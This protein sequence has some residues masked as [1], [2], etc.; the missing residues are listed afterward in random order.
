MSLPGKRW[1]GSDAEVCVVGAADQD[2]ALRLQAALLREGVVCY[3]V[4]YIA[5]LC[6]VLY[7]VLSV[8]LC[9]VLRCVCCLVLCY[10]VCCVICRAA[11][12][13]FLA[14]RIVATGL[15]RLTSLAGFCR[16]ESVHPEDLQQPPK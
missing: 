3:A 8:V 15:A 2:A 5:V 13:C 6:V 12:F 4:C 7:V 1:G 9:C 16:E 14:Y 11:M 10:A